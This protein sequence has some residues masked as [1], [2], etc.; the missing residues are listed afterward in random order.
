MVA[1][2]QVSAAIGCCFVK[3]SVAQLIGA[4]ALLDGRPHGQGV[5]DKDESQ[6]ACTFDEGAF[7]SYNSPDKR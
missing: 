4:G 1:A 6:A 7:V 2:S 3:Y 5:V